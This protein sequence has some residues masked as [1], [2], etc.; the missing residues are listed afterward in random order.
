MLNFNTNQNEENYYKNEMLHNTKGPAHICY[1]K[2]GYAYYKKY[3]LNN[4]LYEE[5]EDKENRLLQNFSI[6]LD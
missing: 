2:S 4:I 5:Y 1:N 3:Y 6:E